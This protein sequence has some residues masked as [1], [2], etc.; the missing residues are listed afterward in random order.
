[1]PH[2]II[3]SPSSLSSLSSPITQH[4][5]ISSSLSSP[6][7]PHS[8]ISSPSSLSSPTT[9]HSI[10][11]SSLSSLTTQHSIISSS[12][13]SLITLSS[14]T[15]SLFSPIILS[16]IIS[17]MTMHS[18]LT[19]TIRQTAPIIHSSLISPSLWAAA[20]LPIT[21]RFSQVLQRYS[22]LSRLYAVS[23]QWFHV[24]GAVSSQVS[25][26][27]YSLFW[28]RKSSQAKTPLQ[29]SALFLVLSA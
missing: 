13:F 11:S 24:V 3:S 6:I 14:T 18:S 23:F 16:S 7:M 15:S 27:L 25:P 9:Q 20:M 10:I 22:A 17:R 28:L 19:S 1:M 26:Q 5:I 29:H 21:A 12:L 2:S 4:S 8:I